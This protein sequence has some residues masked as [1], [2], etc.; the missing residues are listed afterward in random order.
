MVGG[1]VAAEASRAATKGRKEPA[2]CSKKDVSARSISKFEKVWRLGKDGK[3]SGR[4]D[5]F[6]LQTSRKR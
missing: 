5:R 1:I 4:T 6:L 3:Y 2:R